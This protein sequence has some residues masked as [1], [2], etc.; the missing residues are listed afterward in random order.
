MAGGVAPKSA[1]AA[2]GRWE[3]TG[4][5]RKDDDGLQRGVD[6]LCWELQTPNEGLGVA[7]NGVLELDSNMVPDRC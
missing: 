4:I 1:V 3:I 2:A 6:S 5:D 7:L